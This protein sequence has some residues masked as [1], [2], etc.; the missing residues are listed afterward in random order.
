MTKHFETAATTVL[1]ICAVVVATFV[2]RGAL[3]DETP[4]APVVS[5]IA[6]WPAY[7]AAGREMGN[8][9]ANVSIVIFSDFQCP[10][11][12]TL[13][14]ELREYQ[15]SHPGSVSVRYRHF[16]IPGHSLARPAALAAECAAQQE[17]FGAYHDALFESQSL[18]AKDSW[19]DF[20]VKASVPNL[21]AFAHCVAAPDTSHRIGQ[22][23]ADGRRL[24]MH[25]T[26][27]LLINDRLIEGTP[28]MS[29][30]VR[31]VAEAAP[32]NHRE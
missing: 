17:R 21:A 20:A 23:E 32:A 5:R 26:P 19:Q 14:Q 25:V 8:A 1:V 6:D 16:P 15:R 10:A 11:C 24:K 29:D 7:A 28:S 4:R 13:A 9:S 27:T 2:V 18:I 3:R 22:D 30:L 31:Y 12:A